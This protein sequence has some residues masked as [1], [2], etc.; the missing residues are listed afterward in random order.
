MNHITDFQLNEYL[1]N[2]LELSAHRAVEAHLRD[3]NECRARLDELQFVLSAL[4]SLTDVRLS[5]DISTD[6]AS[7]LPRRPDPTF[8]PVFAIQLG[9]ALGALLF[10]TVELAQ[11]IRI[12]PASTFQ[13]L[14]P[15]VRFAIPNFQIFTLYAPFSIINYFS[16]FHNS[17]FNLPQL[18]TFQFPLSGFQISVI[19]IFTLLL[20]LAGNA[21]LLR[22]R[23]EVR[24]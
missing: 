23:S 12:P 10:V 18:P 19:A 5:Q 7:R 14:I 24:K 8:T 4:K 11:A 13:S 1:D 21:I 6:I 22:E 2:I 3:C 17:L 9:A 20:W 15:E 16:L